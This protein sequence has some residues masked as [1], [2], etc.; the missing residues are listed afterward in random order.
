VLVVQ[1]LEELA[2]VGAEPALSP[3][4]ACAHRQGAGDGTGAPAT[5]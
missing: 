3:C 4:A 5:A 2:V 1:V